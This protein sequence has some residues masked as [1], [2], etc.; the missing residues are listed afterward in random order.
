MRVAECF[1]VWFTAITGEKGELQRLPKIC[2]KNCYQKYHVDKRLNYLGVLRPL[3]FYRR[4]GGRRNV[5][6]PKRPVAETSRRRNVL[7]PKRPVAELA[8]AE[9]S[10]RRN[11]GRRTGVAEWA[12]PKRPISDNPQ[13]VD[14]NWSKLYKNLQIIFK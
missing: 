6:S 8:V 11:G 1:T 10:H 13:K 3:F 5:P 14:L 4:N 2:L 12:S 9:T 7:S